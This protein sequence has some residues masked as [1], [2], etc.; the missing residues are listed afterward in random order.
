MTGVLIK[1]IFGPRST[2][3]RTAYEDES[4]D[5]GDA[6]T[7]QGTPKISNKLPEGRG[8]SWNGFFLTGL[9]RNQPCRY[10]DLWFWPLE[11]W[12]NKYMSLKPLGSWYFVMA[13]LASQYSALL[14]S[15][16]LWS[17]LKDS[18]QKQLWKIII[19][20]SWAWNEWLKLSSFSN[21]LAYLTS[22]LYIK[23]K[24]WQ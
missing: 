9:R 10:L 18:A 1:G 17:L 19:T 21:E 6:S 12:D 15:L 3:R 5:Q 20:L 4:R 23:P 7:T 2:H 13:A 8:H 14:T 22:M 11:I 24:Q 16:L